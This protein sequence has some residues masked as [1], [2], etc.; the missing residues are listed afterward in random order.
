MVG[1]EE[2]MRANGRGRSA[3]RPSTTRKTQVDALLKDLPRTRWRSGTR[4]RTCSSAQ[5]KADLKPVQERVEERHSGVGG[6]VV[7]LWDAVT[8]LP[9]WAE[10]AYTKAETNFGDGVIA[11]LTAISTNVNAVIAA[12]DLIIKN[13]RERIAKIFDEL[14]ESLRGWA[15]QEKAK[16]DG[17]LDQ[18]HNEV[19][20]TRDNF[21]KDLVEQRERRGR[22]GARRD[23]R[24]AQEGR[25]TGRPD[26]QR[27][28]PVHRGSGQVHHRGPARDPRHPAGGVLGRRRQDQ[29]GR[30]GDRRRPDEASRTTCSQGLAQ[31]F[32]LF[33]DNFG[34]HLLKGFLS[35]LL[36]GLK[37]V[38]VPKD[39]SLKSI[40]TFFLQLMGITWPNIR[41]ILVKQIGAKNVALIE[42]V[43]S[44]VSLL[45]EKGP[46][47]IYEMIKE[48]LD[49]QAIVDQVIQLAVDYMVVGHHQ[50]GRRTHHHAVQPRRRDPPGARGDLPGPEVDLPERREDLHA[51]RDRR[52]RHRRHPR[53]QHRRL[54]QGGRE[55]PGDADRA[56]HLASSPTT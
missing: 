27:D 3:S 39:L 47:G 52:E 55:G 22:R 14:P 48:K 8:G 6:F 13:A 42:K 49:P 11:K 38:Q 7:G 46:E 10:E 12:C 29:E 31:G 19:V 45:I 9:D 5:F 16:F 54:R 34:T 26:R 21:N 30:Q 56:G 25:R 32:G 40:V 1:S 15:A 2:S 36:G 37:D 23:R 44:L 50:A 24:A 43:Y 41:K 18:L 17:Q 4:R 53:R 20:A 28:Q 35:W 51:R 33:F